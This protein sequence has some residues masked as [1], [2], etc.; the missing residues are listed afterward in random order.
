M[1]IT[2]TL[3]LET[4][5]SHIRSEEFQEEL[6]E[7]ITSAVEGEEV[8]IS[9]ESDSGREWESEVSLSVIEY[10]MVYGRSKKK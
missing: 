6:E 3:T 9:G 1:I 4:E 10:E 7:L 2:V 5:G 8:S